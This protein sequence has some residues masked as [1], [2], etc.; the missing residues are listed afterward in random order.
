MI[1]Y[2]IQNVDIESVALL[3]DVAIHAY[4]DHYLHLWKNNDAD[5]Y[6]NKCFTIEVLTA[7]LNDPNNVFYIVFENEKPL[8]FFKIVLSNPLSIIDS[9]CDNIE[10]FE[11]NALYLERIYFIKEAVGKGLG[12]IAFNIALDTAR[13]LNKKIIWLTAMDSSI[14]TIAAYKRMGFEI[15]G[16]KELDFEQIKDEMRGMVIMKKTL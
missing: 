3:S 11:E 12:E 13:R 14:K 16:T 8:G 10:I 15:C 1:N 2:N 5:W 9:R 4:T 7:E 6:I